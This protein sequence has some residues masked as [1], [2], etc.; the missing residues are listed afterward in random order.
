MECGAM[1]PALRPTNPALLL[2]A[3]ALSLPAGAAS[4]AP[5]A[6]P[7][8]D[9]WPR[10]AAI[11]G[12]TY[13]VYPPQVDSW[14]G[15][16][17]E[18]HCAASVQ[19]AGEDQPSVF[20]V[21]EL[22]SSTLTD[23]MAR[24]VEL[25]DL[26]VVKASFPALPDR[27]QELLSAFQ[28]MVPAKRPVI[29]LDR[30]EAQLAI[31]GAERKGQAQPVRNDPPRIVFAETA[32]ALVAIDGPPAWRPVEKTSLERVINTRALVLRDAK[33]GLVLVHVLDGWVGA[34]SLA[35]P[36][37]VATQVPKDVTA[38][39]KEAAKSGAADLMEG[40]EDPKTKKRPSLKA[41]MPLVVVSEVPTEVIHFQGKPAW[42]PIDGTNLIYVSNTTGN[43]FRDIATQKAYVLISGRWFA[44][45]SMEGPWAF[46]P[47]EELPP[48]FARI[49]DTSPKE[50]VKASVPGTRQA[51]EAV[52]AAGIPQ[53]AT[54][55]R[56]KATFQPTVSGEPMLRPVEGTGLQ[57]V[58]NSPDP[59]L[60]VTPTQWYAVQNA[61]W[62]TA[63]SV[64]GPWVVA[65][66]VPAAVY[67]IPVSSPV[68][69]VTYVRIYSVTPTT[70]V[71][72]YTPGYMGTVVTPSGVVVYGTGY[73]Y[74]AYVGPTVWYGPPVTYGYS[75]NVTYTPWTG[76]C[77]GFMAVGMAWY[78]PP[79]YWGPMRPP[80][81]YPYYRP[82]AGVAYGA[83]GGAAAWGPGGW[84]ATSGNVYSQWGS[85]T[86]VT[87]NS[88]G[89]NAWTGNAWA[90]QAGRSYN[91]ATGQMSAGQ[92]GS[93]QNVYTGNYAYG[94]RGATYNPSTGTGA[95]GSK[96]TVGNQYTGNEAT[97]GRGV[98]TGP[99]GNTTSVA[100]VKG[101]QGSAVRVGDT[102]YGSKDGN[103]Y[104]SNGQGGY[105]QVTRPQGSTGSLSA[106]QT[107]SLQQQQAAR[108]T[109][110]QR[111]SAAWSGGGSS[112]Y[113]GSRGSSSGGSRGGGGGGRGGRR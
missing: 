40:P 65:T 64:K 48:D 18:F 35:G 89:Y 74:P 103:V 49:P 6:P 30:I 5:A 33:A 112:S 41:G 77:F 93:V 83:Y 80:Y 85:T 21:L 84:A 46:V 113:S 91:S 72:G 69:Y 98:V 36:W 23:K 8:S 4:P 10:Q 100:G 24:V 97:A 43:V 50:N 55:Y 81:Y 51:R 9:G 86:A 1:R 61:V 104:K 15:R 12:A 101:E 78:A 107:Q 37:Q 90:T 52:I 7:T 11:A 13:S 110:Q 26:R 88:A 17:I 54:V 59:I 106:S 22:E 39:A 28:Q 53:T 82:P 31:A 92:R 32:A 19:A 76:W 42:V 66:S 57:Y 68:H 62:F 44:A 71:V 111:S 70:V 20:G 99:G 60:M 63:P 102:Y 45:A 38:V 73:V 56:E 96:V 2:A 14:D 25:E 94:G 3:L 79:P 67:A 27:E 58:F 16:R 105:E 95:A 29:A 75:V 87:R 34:P 47:G 109:G 108:Q